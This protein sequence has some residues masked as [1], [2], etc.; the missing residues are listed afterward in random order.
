MINLSI[1][2]D[3]SDKAENPT[4][5]LTRKDGSKIGLLTNIK[6]ITFKNSCE[7]APEMIVKV[8][9]ND[10]NALTPF[11]DDINMFKL[12]YVVEMD[13]Y[14]AIDCSIS[15]GDDGVY[16]SLALTRLS[17]AELEQI[18]VYG[19][20]I[21]TEASIILPDYDANFPV[22]LY[23]D[24]TDLSRYNTIWA[25]DDKYTVYDPE[26][27]EVDVAATT[28]LRTQ[29][30]RDSS[31]LH[32]I[33]SFAPHYHIGNVDTS[34]RDIQRIFDFN[35]IAITECLKTI[36]EEESII[37]DFSC[38]ADTN[39]TVN[40]YDALTSC[41]TC[42]YR[43]HFTGVCPECGGIDL[44]E[45]FGAN[46][47]ILV[48][49][50]A[51]GNN[52]QI[53]RNSEAICNCYHVTGGD[54]MMTAAIRMCN[55]NGGYVWCF[56]D[57]MKDEMSSG[58][59]TALNTYEALY[60]DY[61]NTHMFDI[62]GLPTGYY[63]YIV[64]K[65]RAMDSSITVEPITTIT[66]Y[67]ELIE[68]YYGALDM[69]E[70]INHA[71]MPSV[72]N[73]S[74]T[75]A[76]VVAGLTDST[77]SPVAVYN[78]DTLS[79]AQVSSAIVNYAKIKS[80]PLYDI[81]IVNQSLSRYD[82][83]YTWTGVLSATNYY[84]KAD[85]AKTS[86]LTITIEKNVYNYAQNSVMQT[87]LNRS[88]G[89]SAIEAMY[90]MS[91]SD[92]S[93]TL[94]YYSYQMLQ[95]INDCFVKAVE[96]LTSIGADDWRS[97]AYMVYINVQNKLSA[98]ANAL[99]E[100]ESEA[101][102]IDF[103]DSTTSMVAK[104][105]DMIT[106]TIAIMKI[107]NNLTAE[108]WV[109]LN[110]FRREADFSNDNYVSTS[111]RRKFDYTDSAFISDSLTN[112]E[113]IK[114]A[115]EFVLQAEYKIKENNKY[116]YSINTNLQNLLVINEFAALRDGFQV[117]NWIRIMDSNN[118]LFK[119]RLLDYEIDFEN[120]NSINVNFADI[121]LD[122]GI[123]N[124][125][126]KSMA[127]TQDVVNNF[128]KTSNQG[129]SN[130]VQSSDN[131]SGD[132]S[133]SDAYGQNMMG[134][135]VSTTFNVLDGLIEG[136]ISRE[137]ALSLIAQEL[138]KITLTVQNGDKASTMTI[139]YDGV[140]ISTSGDITLGGDVIFTSNLT[141]GQTQISGDN[142]LTGIIQSANFNR[143]LGATFSTAGSSFNLTTGEL[144]TPAIHIE[145]ISQSGDEPRRAEFKDVYMESGYIGGSK[146]IT[147]D[148]DGFKALDHASN[149]WKLR[150]AKMDSTGTRY[151]TYMTKNKNLIVTNTERGA[152]G[153]SNDVT[154]QSN[155][156][157]YKYPWNKGYFNLLRVKHH[158]VLPEG[159]DV[160]LSASDWVQHTSGYYTLTMEINGMS[161]DIYLY[162]ATKNGTNLDLVYKNKIEVDSIST[163]HVTFLA[164]SI[165][166]DGN[167]DPVDVE[168]VL[169][170]EDFIYSA[171]DEP[172]LNADFN[173]E[174]NQLSC[175]WA[176]PRDSSKFITWI[177]DELIIE[178]YDA[179][180]DTWE[181]VLV[182]PGQGETPFEPDEFSDI[183]LVIGSES[184]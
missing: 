19:L 163:D 18:K 44:N 42:G 2:F 79:L 170:V 156:G 178:K 127:K 175:L 55:P 38:G 166:V 124:Q 110:A 58:L 128:Y 171:I 67:S 93:N 149:A 34:I 157:S 125:M 22:V 172:E 155:I 159:L 20:Q 152:H 26:T 53:T 60:D 73:N 24:L 32:K 37:F 7:N 115:Y 98:I 151:Y 146:I 17:E 108:Q 141:D 86:T 41:N 10:G 27:H 106:S 167:G 94:R 82:N 100:R 56:S 102:A 81:Q 111:F 145:G 140:S 148:G 25:S 137:Q 143:A 184:E 144:I 52:L 77:M 160:T 74:T 161:G 99:G 147:E 126:R 62:S 6:D 95:N 80:D 153:D 107:E 131:I 118:R 129:Q 49:R 36:A 16:K 69:G 78:T 130:L 104:L 135:T 64:N 31:L 173:Q 116:S 57:E 29:I 76:Q 30:L 3:T 21:N 91:T 72:T 90:N 139:K 138:D 11:W 181:Q 59:K 165:P 35:G 176:S 114:R 33:F 70:Y 113:L 168:I 183:P 66:G 101:M 12:I 48:S 13:C 9:K 14:F 54:D 4:C 119:L 120:L 1:N 92:L 88:Q 136:K 96:M 51:L 103:K 123:V 97:D 46:T 158:D 15:E 83:V 179:D 105:W 133:Y 121:S 63:N 89:N 174:L 43:G 87:L 65:Y 117:G 134:G 75:A 50:E 122:N 71:L 39:R 5:I 68:A 61:Q 28:A 84:D 8:Y 47:G 162:I 112:A 182:V 40:A 23:R 85:T 142:I 154:D 169:L 109:E 180:N 150:T 164:E 177:S 45:G 132:Y